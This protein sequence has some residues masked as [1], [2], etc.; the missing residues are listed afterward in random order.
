MLPAEIIRKKRNG[1]ILN[2]EE[3]NEFIKG[4]TSGEITDPQ[5]AAM[6]MAIFLNGMSKEETT[7][8]TMARSWRQCK[9]PTK[10]F[11]WWTIRSFSP[12]SPTLPVR[13]KPGMASLWTWP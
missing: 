7:A 3:I 2:K 10:R 11:S 8:L 1:Q 13:K 6:T 12:C 9:S 4:V 5:T